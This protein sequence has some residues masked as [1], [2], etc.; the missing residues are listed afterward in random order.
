[1]E[2]VSA[3]I[4]NAAAENGSGAC[5]LAIYN[6]CSSNLFESDN[7]CRV[8]CMLVVLLHCQTFFTVFQ[9]VVS[10]AQLLGPLPLRAW[11]AEPRSCTLAR[12]WGCC[13]TYALC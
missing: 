8:A 1:M 9:T 11:A 4:I 7:A 5:G 10:A 12:R 13:M 6:G 2:F 3:V